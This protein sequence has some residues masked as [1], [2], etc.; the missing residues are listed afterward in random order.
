MWPPGEEKQK[1][2]VIPQVHPQGP[3]ARLKFGGEG[4]TVKGRREKKQMR[5]N[6]NGTYVKER[7]RERDPYIQIN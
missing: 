2:P 5:T 4:A 6:D 3:V 7:K 1:E